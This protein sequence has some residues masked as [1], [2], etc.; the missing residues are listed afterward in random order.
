[1]LVL[2]V[3]NF[4]D[5]SFDTVRC[6]GQCPTA[7]VLRQWHLIKQSL[8]RKP[9][10][11][12]CKLIYSGSVVPPVFWNLF[13]C[14]ALVAEFRGLDFR[15]PPV[16]VACAALMYGVLCYTRRLRVTGSGGGH[17]HLVSPSSARFLI[18]GGNSWKLYLVLA[19]TAVHYVLRP[20]CP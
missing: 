18:C 12:T 8:Q 16:A 17:G 5:I 9:V 2:V 4:S 6:A 14:G 20:A 19:Y 1:M 11:T 15:I 13:L 7:A 10:G 3:C